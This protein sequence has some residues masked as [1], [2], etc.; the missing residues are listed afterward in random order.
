MWGEE[1]GYT[2]VLQQRADSL[3]IKILLLIRGNQISQVKEFSIL[4]VGRCKHLGWLNSFLHMYL[5]SLGP[6]PVSLFP[7]RS[8]RWLLLAFPRLLSSHHGGWQHMLDHS[9]GSPHSHLEARS[10]WGVCHFLFVDMAGDSFIS[11]SNH[12]YQ[13]YLLQAALQALSLPASL[14]TQVMPIHHFPG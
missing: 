2:E 13:L 1:P 11:H 6:N 14:F 3:N 12:T 9:L 4:C 8:G 5:S 7:L 10:R